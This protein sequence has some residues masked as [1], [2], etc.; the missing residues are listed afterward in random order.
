MALII[1]GASVLVYATGSFVELVLEGTIRGYFARRRMEDA[2]GKLSGHYILCG[3]GRVGRQVAKEFAAEGVDFV[4]IDREEPEVERCVEQGYLVLLGNA[5]D[6]AVLEDAGIRRARGLVAAVDS[7]A[8]NLFITFSARRM[9]PDLRIVGRANSEE[10]AVKLKQAGADRSLSPYAVEGRR[11][12]AFAIQP[13]V[14]DFLD[15]VAHTQ[16]GR[17]LHLEEL[18][19]PADSPPANGPDRIKAAEQTEA[20][21]MAVIDAEGNL[22]ATVS[23]QDEIQPGTTLVALGT[24]EQIARLERFLRT[25]DL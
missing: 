4:V 8:D 10:S 14:L 7:D 23:P 12:A 11:L 21:I 15:V 5:S 20:K 1:T 18:Q 19:V 13:E 3:Y 6:N 22:D 24:G 17:K 9:N 25:G 2:I 16:R